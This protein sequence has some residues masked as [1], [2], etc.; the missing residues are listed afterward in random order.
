MN[1]FEVGIGKF[2]SSFGVLRVALVNS[3]MPFCVLTEAM[4][5]NELILQLCRRPV[6]GPRAFSVDIVGVTKLSRVA[7]IDVTHEQL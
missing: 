3:Q 6:F 1:V 5:P 7:D 4:L 2:V